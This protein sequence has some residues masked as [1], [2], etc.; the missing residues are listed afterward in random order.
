MELAHTHDPFT[1]I[2]GSGVS[3]QRAK[4]GKLVWPPAVWSASVAISVSI[5]ITSWQSP[6]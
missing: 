6:A 3:K 5:A 4:L 2:S 1:L